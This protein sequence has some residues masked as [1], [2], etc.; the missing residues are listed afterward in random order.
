MFFKKSVDSI[1]KAHNK[2]ISKL[3]KHSAQQGEKALKLD[4]QIKALAE[5]RDTALKEGVRAA[6]IATN[7]RSIIS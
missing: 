3:E 2:T 5:Q 4:D 1:L 7:F 6:G